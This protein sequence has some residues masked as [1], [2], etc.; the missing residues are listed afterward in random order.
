MLP[1]EVLGFAIQV[2]A[3][4]IPTMRNQSHRWNLWKVGAGAVVVLALS[5]SASGAFPFSESFESYSPGTALLNV[6]GW[7]PP[8]DGRVRV[9]DDADVIAELARY[10][11]DEATGYPLSNDRARYLDVPSIAVC[12]PD[13]PQGK[14]VWADLMVRFDTWDDENTAP[15][16]EAGAQW[17]VWAAPGGHLTVWHRDLAGGSN[18]WTETGALFATGRW[19]RL[20]VT[21]DYSRP[22]PG[23][24]TVYFQVDLDGRTV[25]SPLAWSTNTGQGSLGGTWFA[26]AVSTSRLARL[27]IRGPGLCDDVV[28]TTNNPYHRLAPLGT[29]EWWLRQHGMTGDP[30]LEELSDADGDLIPAWQ[31]FVAGTLPNNQSSCLQV[32]TAN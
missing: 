18:L 6:T 14:V 3:G 23:H 19:H 12:N 26:C 4:T 9:A 13:G 22:N 11:R 1:E 8:F 28:V 24:S 15:V 27:E 17:G 29:P 32:L 25:S 16:P 5:A 2:A 10:A 7:L 21:I 30:A 31:E 20:T